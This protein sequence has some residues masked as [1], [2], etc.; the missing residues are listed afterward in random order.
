M[1]VRLGQVVI[2][3]MGRDE[4]RRYIVVKILDDRFVEVSDGFARPLTK[5]KKKNIQHLILTRNHS[6]ELERRLLMGL[7]S[8]REIREALL[9][10]EQSENDGGV[11]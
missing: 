4:G 8:D 1:R 5:P 11:R 9:R 3:R 2:S 10:M 7:S 6:A